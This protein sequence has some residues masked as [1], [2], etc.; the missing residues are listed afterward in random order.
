MNASKMARAVAPYL[1]TMVVALAACTVAV[2]T[3]RA[4]PA[5]T[6]N[7]CP[8]AVWPLPGPLA[9]YAPTVRVV[10]GRFVATT[11]AHR[12]KKPKE[13]V[14]ARTTGV[15]LVSG[16]LPSGWIKAEC[17][18]TVWE[19]SVAVSVYFPAMD[20]PHNP[21]GRCNDCDHITLITS[22]TSSGWTVWGI[23]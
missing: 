23:Y 11:L 4:V 15:R 16:W 7:G 21:I 20:L 17:G 6:F 18:R 5:G 1:A 3:P 10:V 14:G 12:S 22:R 2:A 19:R 8:H 13:F 9:S